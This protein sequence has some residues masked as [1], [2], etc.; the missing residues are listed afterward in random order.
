LPRLEIVQPERGPLVIRIE[1]SAMVEAM[2]K[3]DL[4][5]RVPGMVESLQLDDRKA[6]V[7]IGRRVSAGEPLI[8]LA[9][10]DLEAD[11]KLKEALLDQAE[12]QKLQTLEAR[13]VATKELL[14]AQE[15]EKR[16]QAE[17]NRSKEKH[18]RTLKLVQR[19]AL[20]PETAEETKSQLEAA[21]AAWQAAKAQIGTKQARLEAT[22]A[23]LKVA[24]SRIKT[25]RAEVQ[26]LEVLLGYAT[27]RAPFDG[28]VTKRWVDRGAMIKDPAV[29]LLTLMRTNVV[30][31][32][33]DIPER[34]IPLVNSAEQNPN[35]DGKGDP[36]VLQFPA[37]RGLEFAGHVTRLAAALDPATR[38][39][40][41]EV[42]LDNRE[43]YLRPGMYGTASVTLDERDYVLT[44]PSTALVRRGKSVEV[45]Y[46]ANP[47]GEPP[48]GV[49]QR[50]EV[51]LGLDDGRRVEIRNGLT[52]KEWVIAKGNGVVR[53][54]DTVIAVSSPEL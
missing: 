24:E 20:Q 2:E 6:E 23:D 37:L 21:S 42:H 3:A 10:P 7:D 53:E 48:R 14:E 49:V 31:V 44:V 39:M 29:P 5:A 40:R 1:L 46:V 50:A 33:L 36:V 11:K 22:D 28:I 34:D 52:G 45:F 38:T 43:G 8:K 19:N 47:A 35:P 17:F 54:G 30:R 16:Y 51:E 25:A 41:A 13:N 15:Q 32:L 26:R 18:D 27:I 9:V 12:K 4:C